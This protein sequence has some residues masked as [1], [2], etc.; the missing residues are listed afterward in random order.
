MTSKRSKL[1]SKRSKPGRAKP[2]QLMWKTGTQ[3][4]TQHGSPWP[5]RRAIMKPRK[6]HN[7]RPGENEPQGRH[8]DR[9]ATK[10]CFLRRWS[11]GCKAKAHPE[12]GGVR[13]LPLCIG[14]LQPFSL[15]RS[16]HSVFISKA[17]PRQR[18]PC[19]HRP[20]HQSEKMGDKV[21]PSRNRTDVKRNMGGSWRKVRTHK[22]G[23]G[24]AR[25]RKKTRVQL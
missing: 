2:K 7:K 10:A 19:H 16:D 20:R 21:T 18:V 5:K 23:Q 12:N 25:H 22:R 6:S 24:G 11:V 13:L 15:A 8:V 3:T 1:P 4:A 9:C 14:L 17:E